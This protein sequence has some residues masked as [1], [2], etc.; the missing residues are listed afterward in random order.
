M[1]KRMVLPL[2]FGLT[3]IAILL[4]LGCWQ[5]QRLEW[6]QEVIS[7]IEERRSGIPAPLLGNYEAA[8][9][10]LYN[11]LRVE[12]EGAI[13]GNEAHVY[14]PQKIGLGY[15]IVSEFIWNEKSLFVDL[16][17]VPADKKNEQRPTGPMKVIGY[18]SFPDDHDDS[19][20][21]KPDIS[22]NV[23]FSRFVPPM[24]QHFGINPFLIVAE[25]LQIKTSNVWMDYTAVTPSPISLEIKNDH[26]EYAFTWFLLAFVWFGMT[27]YLLWRIREKTV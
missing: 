16:G 5:M 10:E 27:I 6:K 24:A 15:R 23:W 26:K 8:T 3:G 19:F 7:S 9:S 25:S 17:W 14:A 12:F 13:T 4:W 1:T 20:T 21:P 11:Y 18:I 22:N 2:I